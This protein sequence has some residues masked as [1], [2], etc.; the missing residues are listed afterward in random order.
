MK[1]KIVFYSYSGN[2]RKTAE[3]LKSCLDKNYEVESFEL[4]AEDESD[5]F[6][7]QAARAFRKK[8]AKLS[9][10]TPLDMSGCDILAVGSPVWAFGPAPAV[11]SFLNQCSGIAGKKVI[12]FTTYGS[13]AGKG[14]CIK[15]MQ[16]ILTK[17]SA[18]GF[19]W[20][21]VQQ[22]RVRDIPFVEQKIEEALKNAE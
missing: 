17:K 2:T 16:D 4:K 11:R 5:S 20:F 8:E 15:Q 9:A 6:L 14:N 22:S 19:S 13:G 12:I 21:E 3:I 1:A 10:D 7:K 18:G